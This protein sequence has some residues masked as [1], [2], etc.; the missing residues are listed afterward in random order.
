M[1]IDSCAMEGINPQKYDEILCLTEKWFATVVALPIG[2]RSD[3]DKYASL[4]KVRFSTEK[5]SEII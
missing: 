1:K 3:T 2:Y 4:K 5:I